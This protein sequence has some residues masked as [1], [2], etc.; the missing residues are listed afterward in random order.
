MAAPEVSE[1]IR[2]PELKKRVIFTLSMLVVYR[3]G[4]FV[5]TPG[6]DAEALKRQFET[7]SG[8]LFGMINMFSGGAL[9]NFSVFALGIMPYISVSII[10]QLLTTAVKRLEE[11]QKEGEQGR[12][13]ITRY[14]R[15]GTIGL[16][17]FQGYWIS[18]GLESQGVVSDP[19]MQFRLVTALT[20]TSGTAFIMWLGEQISERG[21]GNGM[22]I[23]I[24]AGIVAR[25]P[26][27]LFTTFDLMSTGEI[28]P[29]SVLLILAIG[30]ATIAFIVFVE[31]CQRRI[32]IQYPRRAV[33]RMMTQASTQHLPL[34]LNTA[35]VVPAIFASAFLVFPAT[36]AQFS[37][38]QAFQDFM[39]YLNPGEVVY[40]LLYSALILFFCF[41]YTA[42]VFD[43]NKIS[44]DLKKNGGFI[45]T[46]RPGKDTASFLA[47]VLSRITLWGGLY[48]VI[49]CIVPTMSYQALG[50]GVFAAFFGGTA[51]LIVVGVTLDTASQIQSYIVNKNYESFLSKNRD[52][53]GK[54]RGASR[55]F[56]VKGQL[57]KR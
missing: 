28:T 26:A 35:G 7:A 50:A 22:S 29:L 24:F 17:L 54:V 4:V 48:M 5:P 3:L 38:V 45:P 30:I 43:P 32:P 25:M 57:I 41:F 14:T 42:I 15:F 53:G 2:I 6:I 39:R 18:V 36:I 34:K 47:T 37:N 23:I 10:M 20:L 12:R 33:G 19:G 1:A 40:E 51:V 52:G 31:R 9:E 56:Q 55:G 13:V 49:V 21:I 27:T 16:A 46:V 8:T 11:L 44:E